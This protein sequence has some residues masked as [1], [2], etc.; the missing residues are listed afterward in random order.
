MRAWSLRRLGPGSTVKSFARDTAPDRFGDM[1]LE[2]NLE[3]RI[4][5]TQ[6]LGAY[7]METAL[8]S[9]IGNVWFL[10]KNGD[11]PNGEF[12]PDRLLKDVAV[13]VGTGL[14][15]DFGFLLARFDFAWKAKDPSPDAKDAAGQNKWFYH[16]A[17]RIGNK[18]NEAGYT[19][20]GAQF[21]LGI[22]YPF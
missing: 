21:Q 22:N 16:S 15:I 7:P 19:K 2:L 18:T 3:W 5:L 10:R 14:R 13:G 1:R 12:R 20:Y 11:F 8:F 4:Y 17:F 9:D 6:L